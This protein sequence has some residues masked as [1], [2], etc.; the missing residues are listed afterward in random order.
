ME[1]NSPQKSHSPA[2]QQTPTQQ[3]AS[4]PVKKLTSP[5]KAHKGLQKSILHEDLELS[6]SSAE[7]S[8]ED[9]N[10]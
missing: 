6:E 8:D 3:K 1:P 10:A 4:S 2:K 9:E 5:T 7:S